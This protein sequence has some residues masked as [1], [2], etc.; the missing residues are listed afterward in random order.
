MDI[1]NLL[2]ASA[3]L[4]AALPAQE[5]DPS[6]REKPPVAVPAPK[7]SAAQLIEALGSDSYRARLDAE[8][9]LRAL[10]AAAVPELKKA[11][12]HSDDAEVQWRARRV[13]RL[14]ERGD[15]GE[16]EAKKQSDVDEPRANDAPAERKQRTG[17]R[18]G[19]DGDAMRDQFESLFERLNREFGVD[20][21]RARFFDDDF[22]RDLQQQMKDGMSR[23]QGMTM[24][25]GPDG[26][27]HVEV[28]EKG[29]DGKVDKKVYDAPDLE[30][31]RKQYPGVLDR[32]G[33]GMGLFQGGLGGQRWFTTQ[34]LRGFTFDNDMQ[35]WTMPQIAPLAPGVH[36]LRGLDVTAEPPA[37]PPAGKRLGIS[38]KREIPAE[39]R[40][41]LDLGADVGLMVDAV[42]EGSLAQA[43][44]LQ[45]GD[46]VTR[47]GARSIGSTQDVQEALAPI[48][49]G[50]PVEVQIVR[51]GAS[52][53][54]KA[55][56]TEDV[57]AGAQKAEKGN[58]LEQ[59]DKPKLQKRKKS[60][61][62]I[63]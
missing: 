23:S 1:R 30:T 9:Q 48:A 20:V 60:E 40:E 17:N 53:T 10:G 58:E 52:Q 5:P 42:S 18:R 7:K 63:R 26:A 16:L 28:Q 34:P 19:V 6:G 43:L 49:K 44:G 41:Y 35:P 31:F 59:T 11:A 25:I 33:L 27:V 39:V 62:A 21:P 8:R 45:P 2:L 15:A 57:E 55:D 47:I 38:I 3:A 46:I 50:S 4:V 51:K 13:M 12:E 36:G 22:F 24:Q 37:P 29:E 32:S 61:G 56:K 14:I 54:L